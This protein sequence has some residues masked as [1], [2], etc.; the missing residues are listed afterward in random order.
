[1][2]HRLKP[3]SFKHVRVFYWSGV[4]SI[5]LS[6]EL[7]LFCASYVMRHTLY[8]LQRDFPVSTFSMNVWTK[9]IFDYFNFRGYFDPGSNIYH[10]WFSREEV[11]T[12]EVITYE[13]LRILFTKRWTLWVN[14]SISVRSYIFLI[15][16]LSLYRYLITRR[17]WRVYKHKPHPRAYSI[18]LR[19]PF[20]LIDFDW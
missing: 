7:N 19:T 16:N 11:E 3:A 10:V 17:G 6:H 18:S 13:Y 15:S 20:T 1:M 9:R 4:L 5:P 2:E 8:P 14:L 12:I